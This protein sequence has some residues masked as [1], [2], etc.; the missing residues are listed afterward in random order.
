MKKMLN[1]WQLLLFLLTVIVV[2]IITTWIFPVG[3]TD[4][5]LYPHL[6]GALRN[7]FSDKDRKVKVIPED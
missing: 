2:T 6:D 1:K 4:G 7:K 3:V 5:S